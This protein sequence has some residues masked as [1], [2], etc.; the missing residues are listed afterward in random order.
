MSSL[1][2]AA[3]LLR[4]PTA[5]ASMKSPGWKSYTPVDACKSLVNSSSTRKQQ[6]LE[7][8]GSFS[9]LENSFDFRGV[10]ID[11]ICECSENGIAE[12]RD[13]ALIGKGIDL[14]EMELNLLYVVCF[15]QVPVV[16]LLLE[17]PSREGA[18]YIWI[19]IVE[20]DRPLLRLS[21]STIQGS[22]EV[23]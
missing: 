19:F 21:K 11:M 7:V 12:T 18:E 17:Q 15:S 22:F 20:G 4:N 6:N 13:T 23:A 10:F 5:M 16:E 14:D 2:K 9:S 3:T 8:A 1:P